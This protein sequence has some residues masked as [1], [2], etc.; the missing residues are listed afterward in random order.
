ML[1][2]GQGPAAQVQARA[3]Q[4]PPGHM[5]Q[6]APAQHQAAPAAPGINNAENALHQLQPPQQPA[7]QHSSMPHPSISPRQFKAA[8]QVFGGGGAAGGEAAGGA[9][10]GAEGLEAAA[11]V[12]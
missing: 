6:S 11:A 5:M 10:E 2:V 4:A 7:Q 8:K 9:A 1:P 12:L 3:L